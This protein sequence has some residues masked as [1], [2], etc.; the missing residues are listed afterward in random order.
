[1][2]CFTGSNNPNPDNEI[3]FNIFKILYLVVDFI[4]IILFIMNIFDVTLKSEN[5]S[6]ANPQAIQAQKAQIDQADY[7]DTL[8]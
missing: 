6:F 5:D 2:K 4:V 7:D 8:E 1:M 3:K